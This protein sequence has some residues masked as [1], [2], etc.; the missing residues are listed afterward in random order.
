MEKGNIPIIS[1]D[2]S[3]NTLQPYSRNILTEPYYSSYF[4]NLKNSKKNDKEEEISTECNINKEE[5]NYHTIKK[6]NGI[7]IEYSLEKLKCNEM[8]ETDIQSFN[9]GGIKLKK[10]LIKKTPLQEYL[11]SGYKNYPKVNNKLQM[12]S[13]K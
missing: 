6:E 13:K 12:Y 9:D 2:Y 4:N 1:S 11:Q 10:N 3:N 5:N 7:K 8:S